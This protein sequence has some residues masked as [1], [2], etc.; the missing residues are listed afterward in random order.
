MWEYV[1]WTDMDHLRNNASD[2]LIELAMA[3][4]K[5]KPCL[6]TSFSREC[7][8]VCDRAV[9]MWLERNEPDKVAIEWYSEEWSDGCSLFYFD[10]DWVDS[11][12]CDIR[13]HSVR[14]GLVSDILQLAE[15]DGIL[16]GLD[17]LMINKEWDIFCELHGTPSDGEKTFKRF[18]AFM[19]AEGNMGAYGIDYDESALLDFLGWDDNKFAVWS[20]DNDIG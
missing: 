4:S 7:G 2:G 11:V 9:A 1:D 17:D 16:R 12:I 18:E 3:M 8:S 19:L 5:G 15:R 6:F 20:A 14:N 10:E 13:E